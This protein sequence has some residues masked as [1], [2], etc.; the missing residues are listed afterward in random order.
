METNA[1]YE[2]P[3]LQEFKFENKPSFKLI[4]N[5]KGYN[6]EI[7]STADDLEKC[8]DEVETADTRAKLIWGEQ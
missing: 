7:K 4:K 5:T 1:P 2:S 6:W 3:A 8:I